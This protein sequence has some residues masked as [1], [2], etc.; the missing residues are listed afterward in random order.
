M[1]R[2]RLPVKHHSYSITSSSESEGSISWHF[3][4]DVIGDLLLSDDASDESTRSMDQLV[5]SDSYAVVKV[6]SRNI[7]SKKFVGLPMTGNDNGGDYE[8]K[9]MKRSN[10]IKDGFVFPKIQDLTSIKR[11]DVVC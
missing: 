1:K 3:D 10:K 11:L 9:F 2:L 8:I 7:K 4:S 5:D 6:Y